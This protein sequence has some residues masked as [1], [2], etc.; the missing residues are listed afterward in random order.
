[1]AETISHLRELVKTGRILPAGSSMED[2]LRAIH[3]KK[4]E[5]VLAE[6]QEELPGLLNSLGLEN[7]EE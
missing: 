7:E 3:R 1:M 5:Q 2:D 4:E 6:S